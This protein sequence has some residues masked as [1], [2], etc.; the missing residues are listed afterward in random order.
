MINR[1]DILMEQIKKREEID[2]LYK[3]DLNKIYNSKKQIE[4]DIATI[5][6]LISKFQKYE[7]KLLESAK[8]LLDATKIH[9][10]II[11]LIDK[12]TVYS[13]ML[14]HE[15]MSCSKNQ[16]LVGK[17]S[18]LSDEVFEK[19]AFYSP[20]LLK[21]DFAKINDFILEEKD[22]ETY[23]FVF[24]DLFR[25]KA[26][27]LSLVEE[28]LLARLGEVFSGPNDIYEA[29]DDVDLSFSNVIDENNLEIQLN[30]SNYTRLIKSNNRRVRRDTFLKFYEGYNNFK[31]TF[32][33]CLNASINADYFISK[34]RKYNSVLEMS[35]FSNNIDTNLYDKLISKVNDNLDVLHKY[36]ALKKKVLN[37]DE[38]HMYDMYVPLISDI[39]KTYSYED[40]KSLVLKALEP[41]GSDYINDLENVFNSNCID[42]YNNKNKRGG[43]YSWGCYDSDPYVLLNYEST[44]NDVS[45]VAHELG[46]SMHSYYSNKN[47][48][49]HN[50]S[51]T[52]FLAEIASVVNEILLNKYAYNH[53]DSK[54]EKL[55]YLNNLLESFRT[56]LY[57]QTMFAEFEKIIHE[58]VASNETLTAD[59]LSDV[60]L[61]LN[62][63]YYGDSVI[64]DDEI[65]YEWARI[66]HFYSSFYVYKYATGIAI[67]CRIV[68]D[69]LDN[70]E[71]AKENYLEF[72]K[73]GGKDYSLNILKN[74]G[75]DIVN[76]DTIDKAIEMFN[77]TLEE[78][79]K[80]LNS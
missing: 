31:N 10:D 16:I 77:D 2:D 12:L 25:E 39:D 60:Y 37:L 74:V 55:Y 61:S 15:D 53:A 64:S 29:L 58:M 19:L 18:K 32:A 50:S 1:K 59:N 45:T 56:T 47:Q 35:L 57:R 11:R 22:L 71:N 27:T 33:S 65:S 17:I 75:I 41:L 72:L 48:E 36:V 79:I 67:A 46:H 9:F 14:Y 76:D 40:A 5:K 26:H 21:S 4:N 62:K 78:F 68:S 66:S 34:T 23:R 69:I 20:E 44:F 7:G 73:S 63:K 3:W 24:E 8:N 6:K 13:N 70:K 30:G 49:Y 54:E 80:V 42:V 52:I 38:M 51:Y 28:Q 43:A